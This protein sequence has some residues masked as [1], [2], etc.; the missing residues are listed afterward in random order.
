MESF[1]TKGSQTIKSPKPG[2]LWIIIDIVRCNQN[3]ILS[4][5][6]KLCECG[7]MAKPTHFHVYFTYKSRNNRDMCPIH[8][9]CTQTGHWDPSYV[10]PRKTRKYI[11]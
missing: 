11:I 9:T 4:Q 7:C 6:L 1:H 10:M 2:Q 3:Q 5:L 8:R